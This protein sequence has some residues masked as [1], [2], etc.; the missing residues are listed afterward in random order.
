MPQVNIY[1]PDDMKDRMDAAGERA[2]WSAIAQRAFG[3]ELNHI[4]SIKEINS[5]PDVIERLR[6]SKGKFVETK[7]AEAREHGVAWAK[8]HAEFAELRALSSANLEGL[9]MLSGIDAAERVWEVVSGDE[10]PTTGDLAEFWGF[11]DVYRIDEIS[12]EYVVGWV[13]GAL[14]VWDE[15]SNAL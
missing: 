5:M 10:R 6:A 9:E 13:E 8:T 1:V 2:N 3:L 15:V 12:S 14:S 4:E 7:T 11:D